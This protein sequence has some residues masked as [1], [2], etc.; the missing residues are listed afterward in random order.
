MAADRRVFRV[1]VVGCGRISANHFEAIAR[2]D[3][4]EL[5]AVCDVDA[6][7]AEAAGTVHGV[8][9]YTDYDRMLAASGCDV[10]TVA[11]PSGLHAGQGIAAARAGKHVVC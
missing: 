7:R 10:V 4:L 11:T 3:G 9:W 2:I 1:A 6:A 5:C 8:P